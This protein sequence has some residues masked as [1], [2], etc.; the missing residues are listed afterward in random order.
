MR[1]RLLL[2]FTLSV[3]VICS[4]SALFIV[5]AQSEPTVIIQA[6][7]TSLEYSKEAQTVEFS[8]LLSNESPFAR[9]ISGVNFTLKSSSD[10]L[11][12]DSEA[13]SLT[14]AFAYETESGTLPKEGSDEAYLYEALS[15]GAVTYNDSKFVGLKVKGTKPV[16][17]PY[18]KF[19]LMKIKATLAANAP[20]G[21][22]TVTA[23]D[24]TAAD[25]DAKPIITEDFTCT[26]EVS[27]PPI[28][29]VGE[30]I[31]GFSLTLQGNT[32]DEGGGDIGINLKMTLTDE[33]LAD[34]NAY[35]KVDFAGKTTNVP[36]SEL[37]HESNN[38]Y[39]LSTYMPAKYMSE[40]VT[41]TVYNGSGECGHSYT[42]SIQSYCSLVINDYA[43]AYPKLVPMA[44]A[45][46]NYGG[47]AQVYFDYKTDALANDVLDY[48]S[49]WG[50]LAEITSI[51]G[52]TQEVFS[53]SYD[54][55]GLTDHTVSIIL[56]A[57]T[58]IKHYITLAS[59]QSID[60]YRIE[61]RGQVLT[62][63]KDGN[64]YYIVIDRIP[65]SELDTGYTLSITRKDDSAVYAVTYSVMNYAQ[66]MFNA[67]K[68]NTNYTDLCNLL[69]SIY[70]YSEASNTYF[71]R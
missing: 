12:L 39:S 34:K 62:P 3:L 67:C 30:T 41:S 42:Y 52:V 38:K 44:I 35:V 48:S 13:V 22:Y 57:E 47:A 53:G 1:K 5:N 69:K 6:S 40:T 25:V 51:S 45:L 2:I 17:V 19:V 56:D 46:L 66:S 29:S 21:Q 8:V 55:I 70:L 59:G 20:A 58:V 33:L 60:D 54:S 27:E 50:A 71:G 14:D 49:G 36:L 63:V 65:A 32:T 18:S 16:S 11:V 7:K 28:D 26:I 24:F 31:T 9:D 68:D 61:A 64:R 37:K 4:L 23:E 43:S 15:R 10:Y